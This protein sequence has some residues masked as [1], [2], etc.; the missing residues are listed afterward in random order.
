[1]L[2]KLKELSLRYQELEQK[3]QDPGFMANKNEYAA[4]LREMG[5]LGRKVEKYREYEAVL[6]RIAEAREI[7]SQ[8]TD[9]EFV[10]LANEELLEFEAKEQVLLRELKEMMVAD[11]TYAGKDIIVEIRAGTGGDEASLFATD[12]FRMYQRFAETNGLKIEILSSSE[13]EVGGFKEM[14]FSASGAKAW[15][16]LRYE[17]GGHRVQ[18]VPATESQGRIHTSAATVAVLPE[19]EEVEVEI[20]DADMKVDTFCASGPG[21]QNVN[22]VAT[23]IRITHLPTGIVVQCQ[24]ESSQHKNRSKAIR[25]LKARL[26]DLEQTRLEQERSAERRTQIGSGDRNMRIR[27]YNFPQNRVTDHRLKKN[28]SLELVIAGRLEAM[29][30]DLKRWETAEKIK[31]L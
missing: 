3:I 13:S 12:L 30:D 27:T 29:V 4:A 18:R 10:E 24:D 5:T 23:A 20:N 7:V 22:K 2:E 11:D 17:S 31:A 1:M 9:A 15:E 14:I 25:I 21:G 19:A 26:F 8:E 6:Q 16:L 28:Y